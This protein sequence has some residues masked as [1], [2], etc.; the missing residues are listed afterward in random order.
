MVRLWLV[1]EIAFCKRSILVFVGQLTCTQVAAGGLRTVLL[2]S[3]GSAVACGF[4][5]V[6]ICFIPALVGQL[7]CAQVAAVGLRTVLLRSDGS[8]VA[9]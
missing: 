1:D 5:Y 8:A 3:N 4:Y 9:C 6:G 7:T 2:R